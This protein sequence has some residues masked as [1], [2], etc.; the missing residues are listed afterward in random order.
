MLIQCA[1][2]PESL[3][4]SLLPIARL[5]LASSECESRSR[6]RCP[7]SCGLR[8][9]RIINRRD[10]E[11]EASRC[12]SEMRRRQLAR[13]GA[14]RRVYESWNPLDA[15]VTNEQPPLAA[16]TLLIARLPL[17]LRCTSLSV[18]C[19]RGDSG[20]GSASATAIWE[21]E[22]QPQPQPEGCYAPGG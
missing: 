13:R 1:P 6:C 7:S 12:T 22:P 10:G 9:L 20:K 4:S 5:L 3:S 18:G 19:A 14:V 15:A 17:R 21:R 16:P 11:R 2:L 8:T